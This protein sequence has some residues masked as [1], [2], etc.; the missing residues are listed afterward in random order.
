MA[1]DTKAK[2][3]AAEAAAH[4]TEQSLHKQLAEISTDNR[5][6]VIDTP[7]ELAKY[8]ARKGSV[9]VNGVSL[10]VNAVHGTQFEVN[11]IPHTLAATT[12]HALAA[13]MQVNIEVDTLARYAERLSEFKDPST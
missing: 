5:R 7:R 1:D 3:A 4:R 8:I 6:L 13:R 12:F 9:A 10:T 2:L 11:L